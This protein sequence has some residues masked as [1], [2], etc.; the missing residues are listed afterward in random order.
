M[1]PKNDRERM[2]CLIK[3]YNALEKI[4]DA[5][6]PLFG[7]LCCEG[8]FQHVRNIT[9]RLIESLTVLPAKDEDACISY[10][11]HTIGNSGRTAEDR[12]ADLMSEN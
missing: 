4:G 12:A 9:V 2:I 3:A 5:M 1:T 11:Y 7:E 10:L 6:T 8:L